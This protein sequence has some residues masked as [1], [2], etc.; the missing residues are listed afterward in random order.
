VV[1]SGLRLLG[2]SE[3]IIEFY[4]SKINYLKFLKI[5]RTQT[6]TQVSITFGPPSIALYPKFFICEKMRRKFIYFS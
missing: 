1:L 5:I 3:K 2:Y 4:E 6:Q